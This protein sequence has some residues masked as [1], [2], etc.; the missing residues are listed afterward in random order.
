MKQLKI[1]I[2]GAGIMGRLLAW[3]LVQQGYQITLFDRDPI[4]QGTAAAYTAAGM[5]T[6]YSEIE[7]AEWLIY[8]L[9]MQAIKLWP[10]IIDSLQCGVGF[11]QKGSLIVAHPRDNGDLL[12]FQTQLNSKLKE[13]FLQLNNLQLASLEP[14]L[15]S[16]FS[17][18]LFLP[19]E[20]WLCTKT[21]MATLAKKLLEKP[22]GWH[23]KSKVAAVAPNQIT[24]QEQQHQF[25]WVIDTRGLG[26]KKDLSDLRGVRGEL[27]WVEA[28][29][30]K[31][32]RMVRLMH[33]RYRLYLVPQKNNLYIIGATQI[34]S[35][36]FSPISVRSSLELLSA[37]YSIHPGF[38]EARIVQ[39]RTN[40]RPAFENNLPRIECQDGL[41]RVNGLFRHG[42]LLAPVLAQQTL[43]Y[44]QNQVISESEFRP[45]FSI[46]NATRQSKSQTDKLN[47]DKAE[48]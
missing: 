26:A 7:S 3:Q 40:C 16:Q 38:A 29:E 4:E 12:R 36:D 31:I 32:S 17:H 28:P 41:I 11:Q 1:G 39:T 33:P 23:A 44:I 30:V 20:S 45:I 22:I 18:G 35:E 8:A 34:E 13:P 48:I 6:P 25:D 21:V 9:G 24:C 27:I 19:E 10:D 15:A 37:L 43:G 5:L 46:K 2:A 47:G 14:E 42:F